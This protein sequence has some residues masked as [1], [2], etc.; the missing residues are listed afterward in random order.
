MFGFIVV[1]IWKNEKP[2][3]VLQHRP[4]LQDKDKRER[5]G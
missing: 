3:F 1:L 4:S 2:G 5:P